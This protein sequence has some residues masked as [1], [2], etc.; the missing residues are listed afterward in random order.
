[1]QVRGGRGEA[2]VTCGQG[3]N[4]NRCYL[5]CCTNN[6]ALHFIQSALRGMHILNSV[7]CTRSPNLDA[8]ANAAAQAAG[9]A[10]AGGPMGRA[11][12]PLLHKPHV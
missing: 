4:V 10:R 7:V 1:M 11:A 8:C 3:R 6:A 2:G 9:D 12:A 5:Q